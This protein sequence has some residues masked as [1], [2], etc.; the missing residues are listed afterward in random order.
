MKVNNINRKLLAGL[1]GTVMLTTPLGLSACNHELVEI[2]N[3]YED[4]NKYVVL[5]LD[6]RNGKTMWLAKEEDYTNSHLNQIEKYYNVFNG[7]NIITIEGKKSQIDGVELVS[8]DNFHQY[9]I[10]YDCVQKY[11]TKEEIENLFEKIKADFY[12]EEKGKELVKK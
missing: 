6:T 5:T 10:G 2:K 8:K 12:A 11:Y 7:E 9:L 3:K 1:L 4:V